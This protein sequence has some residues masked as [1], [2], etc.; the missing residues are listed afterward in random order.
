MKNFFL[1]L[2]SLGFCLLIAEVGTRIFIKENQITMDERNL[3]YRFDSQL[4]W[5]PEPNSSQVFNGSHPISVQHNSEGFRDAEHALKNKPR[6]AFFGASQV[7][8]YDVE[9]EQRFTDQIQKNHPE[10]EV[11]NLGVSGYSTD[12]EYLLMKKTWEKYK[13]DVVVF[14]YSFQDTVDNVSNFVH[15]GY[16]KP[17]FEVMQGS[18]ELKGIEVPKSVNYYF[19]HYPRLAKL[20]F[21]SRLSVLLGRALHPPVNLKTDPTN[22]I[23]GAARQYAAT[24]G[25]RFFV[26]LGDQNPD[27]EK[28]LATSQTPFVKLEVPDADRYPTHGFHWKPEGHA[29][30]AQIISKFVLENKLLTSN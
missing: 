25:A 22:E 2:C 1:M 18:L 8:G 21:L 7:W 10:W 30:V 12:Q 27:L 3:M 23:F 11:I 4:G 16:Y 29:K 13:P 15:G 28:T 26:A 6:I 19:A 9:K 20:R 17:Y 14:L 5:F 24:K